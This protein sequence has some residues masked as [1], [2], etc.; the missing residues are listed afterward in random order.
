M[1]NRD[2]DEQLSREYWKGRIIERIYYQKITRLVE[3]DLDINMQEVARGQPH[4]GGTSEM[5][6]A[7]PSK[8]QPCPF[9]PHCNGQCEGLIHVNDDLI[10]VTI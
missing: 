6:R 8:E 2:K 1:R 10:Q 9:C 4:Q 5:S 7:R 3:V